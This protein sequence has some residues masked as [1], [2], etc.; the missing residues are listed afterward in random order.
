L[1]EKKV[2]RETQRR[3]V[4]A[5]AR[6]NSL[7]IALLVCPLPLIGSANSTSTIVCR[8]ELASARREVLAD[9]LREITGLSIEF[10]LN[11][12]LRV[13]ASATQGGSETARRLILKA[14]SGTNVIILEDA[15]D[16]QDVVFSRVVSGK[17]KHYASKMPPTFVILIDFADF[18][19]LLGDQ[20]ALKAFNVGWAFLHELDHV[21]NDSS[22]SVSA[23]EAGECEDHINVMRRECNQPLRTDYF[24]TLFPN[25]EQSD[26]RTRFVRLAFEYDDAI[27]KH[28]RRYW[29][30]WDAT[31]V[32]ALTPQIATAR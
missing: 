8:E 14:L 23:N 15:S 18:D 7:C 25:T 26:F 16:R 2:R 31:L 3:V 10:D 1:K 13:T 4:S 30:M 5:L 29:V 32:G 21:V 27:T 12:A 19:H 22:D 24:Y 20:E 6:I 28:H 17:W 9:K 11:G